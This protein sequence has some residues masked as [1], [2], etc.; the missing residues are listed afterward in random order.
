MGPT[1]GD[2]YVL[3][4]EFIKIRC[5][6]GW[7]QIRAGDNLPYSVDLKRKLIWEDLRC[8]NTGDRQ[9]LENWMARE[10]FQYLIESI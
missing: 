3:P 6:D 10:N 7:Y 2:C 5:N 4:N 8:I 1:T 9:H